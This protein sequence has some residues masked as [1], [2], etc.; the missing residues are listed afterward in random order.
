LLEEV[1]IGFDRPAGFVVFLHVWF[2]L[3]KNAGDSG[4]PKP[5]IKSCPVPES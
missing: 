3:L 4:F 1:R 5:E 2:C